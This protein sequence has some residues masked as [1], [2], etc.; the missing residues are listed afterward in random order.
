LH[1]FLNTAP[2]TSQNK[3]NI[4]IVKQVPE[5]LKVSE[6]PKVTEIPKVTGIP[7]FSQFPQL[8]S[9]FKLLERVGS[10]LS[11]GEAGF[12]SWWEKQL[13]RRARVAQTCA[14]EDL[15]EESERIHFLYDR[16]HKL[17]FCRNAKVGT[18]TWLEHFL[19]LAD[20]PE[21]KEK[22][23][24]PFLHE[25]VPPLFELKPE[26]PPIELLAQMTISF[27]MVRHP[28]ERLVSAYENKV[29]KAPGLY[30]TIRKELKEQFGDLSFTSFVKMII[31]QGEKVC[32][33]PGKSACTFNGHWRPFVSRCAYCTTNYTLI[34][35]FETFKED[36][37][38][39]G[40]L[41]NVT[42]V[43]KVQN[44]PSG[45]NTEQL[46]RKYFA[47]LD[48]SLVEGL[49]QQYRLDFEMFGYH[50]HM[51]FNLE[52]NEQN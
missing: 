26:D 43:E 35:T 28:F 11:E 39:I 21:K 47:Q 29:I 27:S 33:A 40:R 17:L 9:A 22:Q 12:K 25:R 4:V 52:K 14:R 30:A 23:I 3:P 31:D 7:N 48:Q 18:T 6:V 34:A 46:T 37:W 38:Y 41:A 32:S 51:F 24:R 8:P 10:L 5:E 44:N 15:S 16:K 42:F 45:M 2:Q 19:A 50:H 13:E 49:Y 20:L 36:L 1:Q